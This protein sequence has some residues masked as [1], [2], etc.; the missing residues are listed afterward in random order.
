MNFKCGI[1]K[2]KIKKG[3]IQLSYG[4]LD[5]VTEVDNETILYAKTGH[6][7]HFCKTCF[8]KLAISGTQE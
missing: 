8:K 7:L 2:Q 4:E 3:D 5:S 1:C 6:Y